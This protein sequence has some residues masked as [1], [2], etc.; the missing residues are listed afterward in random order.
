MSPLTLVIFI[1]IMIDFI[2]F[3]FH[4][5]FPIWALSNSTQSCYNDFFAIF[6]EISHRNASCGN[7]VLTL[8]LAI[9]AWRECTRRLLCNL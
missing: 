7:A 6:C 5:D 9:G 3:M 1:N 4:I 8:I 2:I